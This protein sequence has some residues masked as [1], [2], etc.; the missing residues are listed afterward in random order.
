MRERESQE[1]RFSIVFGYVN[2]IQV[3]FTESRLL[4]WHRLATENKGI[5]LIKAA[6]SGT[7]PFLDTPLSPLGVFLT[8]PSWPV[9]NDGESRRLSKTCREA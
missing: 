6:P 8:R 3:L 9:S 5:V 1:K 2:V 7:A 4:V